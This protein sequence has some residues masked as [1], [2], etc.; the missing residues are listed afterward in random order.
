[1]E[2]RFIIRQLTKVLVLL[3]AVPVSCYLIW[4]SFVAGV[5]MLSLSCLVFWKI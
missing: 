4:G 2:H 3:V 5:V 1:M